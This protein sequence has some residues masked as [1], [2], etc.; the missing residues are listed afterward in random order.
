MPS[1][2]WKNIYSLKFYSQLSVTGTSKIRA[3]PYRSLRT[4]T[5][6]IPFLRRLQ[7]TYTTKAGSKTWDD[8]KRP[9]RGASNSWRRWWWWRDS[10]GGGWRVEAEWR[11]REQSTSSGGEWR[12]GMEGTRQVFWWE[13]ISFKR[14]FD[15]FKHNWK[16]IYCSVR[17]LGDQLAINRNSANQKRQSLHENTKLLKKE[18]KF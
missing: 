8:C 2:L 6:H 3:F 11:S 15:M 7:K 12:N 14:L 18:I 13:N 5:S 1:K 16:N 17:E 9:R 4:F 10:P